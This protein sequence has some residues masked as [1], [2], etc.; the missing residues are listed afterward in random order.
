LY[1]SLTLTSHGGTA[2][3]RHCIVN[4]HGYLMRP[5]MRP[6]SLA[7]LGL[8]IAG[9]VLIVAA[10]HDAPYTSTTTLLAP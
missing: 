5:A 9:P 8:I 6:A 10:P 7:A 2:V 3:A 1:F 4:T